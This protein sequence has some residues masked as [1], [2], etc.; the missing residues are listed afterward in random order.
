CRS[1]TG[2]SP[3]LELLQVATV[4]NAKGSS[5]R[6]VVMAWLELRDIGVWDVLKRTVKEFGEDDMSTY[7]AALAYRMLFAL[8]PFLLFLVALISVL[9]LAEFFD[10]L[11]QQAAL[12][13]PPPALYL[14]DPIIDEMQTRKTGLMSAG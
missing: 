9:H 10:W 13:L 14:V 2:N 11:R 6:R 4:P 8:F 5:V 12:L 1:C 3:E 7:A